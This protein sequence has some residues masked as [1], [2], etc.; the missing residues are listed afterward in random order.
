MRELVHLGQVRHLLLAV[1][2]HLVTL[3]FKAQRDNL[4]SR[5]TKPRLRYIT[6]LS[7]YYQSKQIPPHMTPDHIVKC[8]LCE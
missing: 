7:R 4:F 1:I 5:L 6:D 2:G 8:I 3:E